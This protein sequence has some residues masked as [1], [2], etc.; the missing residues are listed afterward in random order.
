MKQRKSKTMESSAIED[1]SFKPQHFFM[2][3]RTYRLN[4]LTFLKDFNGQHH[5][6]LNQLPRRFSW[7][8]ALFCFSS[9]SGIGTIRKKNLT[10]ENN[11]PLQKYSTTVFSCRVYSILGLSLIECSRQLTLPGTHL[12]QGGGVFSPFTN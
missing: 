3:P 12:N 6:L 9:G 2:N 4:V 1:K 11:V 7:L 5:N 10:E 8:A